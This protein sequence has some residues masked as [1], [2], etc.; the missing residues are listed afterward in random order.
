MPNTAGEALSM[1]CGLCEANNRAAADILQG[2]NLQ[3]FRGIRSAA[4]QVSALASIIAN[5]S[6]RQRKHDDLEVRVQPAYEITIW[7]TADDDGYVFACPFVI[8]DH[9]C[10][11]QELPKVTL[12]Y[13]KTLSAVAIFNMALAC[14]L[15]CRI[16]DECA[17]AE[18]LA[19][20][21]SCLYAQAA[22]LLEDAGVFWNKSSIQ[23]YLAICNNLV[24]VSL[25]QGDLCRARRWKATLHATLQEASGSTQKP[26][27]LNYF[28]DVLNIY[29]GSFSAAGAA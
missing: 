9:I 26:A 21:A 15:Q 2:E 24:E 14:H 18:V 16:A 11:L 25:V 7:A 17:K 8:T 3:A 1:L 6:G 23:V 20:R 4:G 22:Q 19:N 13:M 10:H 5:C 29:T 12:R 28:K 27:L